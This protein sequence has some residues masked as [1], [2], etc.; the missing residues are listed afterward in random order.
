MSTPNNRNQGQD[1]SPPNPDTSTPDRYPLQDHSFTLQLIMEL[2]R[3]SG[4]LLEAVNAVN[5]RLDKLESSMTGVKITMGVSAGIL[6]IVIA[7][8]G[9]F[10]D[11][12]WDAIS[13]HIEVVVKK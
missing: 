3:S 11:K 5:Q 9:F 10:I 12:A 8:S 7:V 2:Q 13:N 1:A 4:Q 6:A